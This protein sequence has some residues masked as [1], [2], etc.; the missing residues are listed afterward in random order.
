MAISDYSLEGAMNKN[1]WLVV[2]VVFCAAFLAGFG[3]NLLFKT[4]RNEFDWWF[5]S[6]AVIGLF[7]LLALIYLLFKWTND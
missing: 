5:F 3:F 2:M 7:S 6:F 1:K 4:G